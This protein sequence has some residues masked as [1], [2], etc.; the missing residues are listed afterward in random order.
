M[1]PQYDVG[2]RLRAINRR[3]AILHALN[4]VLWGLVIA[5]FAWAKR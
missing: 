1:T 4:I 3:A 2:A 5:G